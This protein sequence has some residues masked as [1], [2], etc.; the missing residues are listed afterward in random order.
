MSHFYICCRGPS[1][2]YAAVYV[3]S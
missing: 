1:P 2:G 3:A